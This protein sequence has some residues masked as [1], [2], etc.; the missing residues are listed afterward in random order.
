LLK[1][2]GVDIL[3]DAFKEAKAETSNDWQLTLIGSGDNIVADAP[4]ITIKGFMQ[5]AELA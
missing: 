4:F 5:G 1:L 2:K 3:I